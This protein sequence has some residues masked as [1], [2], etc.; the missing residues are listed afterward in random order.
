MVR[1]AGNSRSPLG[2]GMTINWFEGGRRIVSVIAGL[3]VLGAAFYLFFGGGD[4][5]VIVET[6]SPGERL[7]WTLKECPYPDMDKD[8]GGTVEFKS[9][10][11]RRVTAC[12]RAGTNGK[13]P[14]AL[15][16][17]QTFMMKIRDK[18]FPISYNQMIFGDQFSDEVSAYMSARMSGFKFAPEETRAIGDAQWKIGVVHFCERV[19]YAFPWVAG[20]IIGLWVISAGIGWMVRGFAG[21][22]SGKDFRADEHNQAAQRYKASLEWMGV[23]IGGWAMASG[24]AWVV[25]TMMTP[26]ATVVGNY[27][28]KVIHGIGVVILGI[29]GIGLFFAGG[30]ALRALVY[31]L[32][33]HEQPDWAAQHK[34]ALAFSFANG[35]IVLA[36]SWALGNY[37]IVGDWS[38]ALYRWGFANGMQ[39]G[40]QVA[41][42]GLFLLWPVLPLLVFVR[43]RA[44]AGGKAVA[45]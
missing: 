39:D 40:P 13:I 22:P 12:F 20:L 34:A 1:I 44:K 3:I 32:L 23:A 35:G 21:V 33:K 38:D 41:V 6:S 11:P 7:H 24:A 19:E 9:S 16:P 14:Y 36:A 25:I 37:T 26:A 2:V 28:G 45:E 4:N 18:N 31:L 5:R 15:G 10:D 8:W 29:I 27:T 43:R 30:V 17:K 42:C